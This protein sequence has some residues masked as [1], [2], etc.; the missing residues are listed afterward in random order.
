M[1]MDLEKMRLAGV[2]ASMQKFLLDPP[3]AYWTE[4]RDVAEQTLTN[5]AFRDH[6]IA[7]SPKWNV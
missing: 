6:S 5:L 2:E 3:A 4:G 7:L 1:L